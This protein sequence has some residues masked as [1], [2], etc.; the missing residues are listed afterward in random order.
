VAGGLSYVIA[1]VLVLSLSRNHQLDIVR[2]AIDALFPNR[3]DNGTYI[4]SFPIAVLLGWISPEVLYNDHVRKFY[5][6]IRMRHPPGE[7]DAFSQLQA[8]SVSFPMVVSTTLGQVYIGQIQKVT[9]D[10]DEQTKVV[11]MRVFAGGSRIEEQEG[12]KTIKKVRYNY[13]IRLDSGE[14]RYAYLD[15]RNV[16]SVSQFGLPEFEQTRSSGY[17]EISESDFEELFQSLALSFPGFSDDAARYYE[18]EEERLNRELQAATD[19]Q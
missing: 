3:Q 19:Q 11:V 15:F 13:V 10:I 16:V 6:A 17:S 12:S 9:T 18:I 4:L 1:W 14:P 2:A 8:D 7:T 5:A